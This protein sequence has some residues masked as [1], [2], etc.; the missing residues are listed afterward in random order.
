M[1]RAINAFAYFGGKTYKLKWL[2][3]ILDV[4]VSRYIEPFCGSAAVLLN[5]K[6]VLREVL[7]DAD[8]A[9][10]NVFQQLR[11]NRRNLLNA[12]YFTPNSRVEFEKSLSI[13]G[14]TPLEAARRT[15]LRL[16]LTRTPTNNTGWRNNGKSAWARK[17]N[18]WSLV[19][20]RLRTVVLEKKNALELLEI[21]AS[22][23]RKNPNIEGE[24]LI[25][26]DPP[27]LHTTRKTKGQDYKCEMSIEEHIKFLEI[28][29]S[30]KCYVAIS[31]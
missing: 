25:Y 30:L 26:C 15:L 6:P 11:D 20:K 12:L 21:W 10:V 8:E 9:L 16:Q 19:S 22:R 5:R 28:V 4:P 7:N 27:Y 18:E 13:E 31:G 14:C 3:P 1:P 2:L 24:T 17:L 23:I 29:R